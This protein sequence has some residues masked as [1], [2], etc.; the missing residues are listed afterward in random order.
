LK[1][2]WIIASIYLLLPWIFFGLGRNVLNTALA[3][4]DGILFGFP[5]KIFS[6][7]FELWNPMVQGGMYVLTDP[8]YQTL[9][10]PGIVVMKLFSSPFGYNLLLLMHYS[11]AGFFT[12]LFLRLLK[13]NK[14]SSFIGGLIFMFSG[15]LSAHKSHHAMVMAAA[16]LPVTLYFIENYFLKFDLKSLIFAA[17]SLAMSVYAGYPAVTV[18]ICIVTIPYINYKVFYLEGKSKF[19]EITKIILIIYVGGFFLTTAQTLPVYESLNFLTRSEISYSFFTDYSYKFYLL[20]LMLFPNL[21]GNNPN[22]NITEFAGYVGLL[23]LFFLLFSFIF[24][25]KKNSQIYF[26]FFMVI[27]SF[28]LVLGNST[29]FYK[30]MYH[31]P[32]YNLFRVP[33]RN[34]LEVNFA[35]AVLSAMFLH[36][37]VKENSITKEKYLK[38]LLVIIAIFL[39]I[40]SFIIIGNFDSFLIIF[41]D[42]TPDFSLFLIFIIPIIFF[43]CSSTLM[44]SFYGIRINRLFQFIILILIFLDL[45]SFGYFHDAEYLISANSLKDNEIVSF[46]KNKKVST[47]KYRILPLKFENYLENV[48]PGFNML[49]D[50]NVVNG[51]G[52]IWLQ[53]YVDLTDFV[54]TGMTNST[55]ELLANP[56]II[57][58]LSTKY[59]IVSDKNDKE[60]I[61]S[62]SNTNELGKETLVVN[63]GFVTNW[64]MIN[65]LD[66][67]ENLFLLRSPS[68]GQV[69]LIQTPFLIKSE[70][71]YEISFSVQC[72]GN[73]LNFAEPLFVD[74][75][76]L[77]NSQAIY[78][79]EKSITASFIK[80]NQNNNYKILFYAG[81]K[82]VQDVLLRI[83]TFSEQP[84][85][86]KNIRLVEMDYLPNYTCGGNQKDCTSPYSKVYETESG[87]SIYENN[88]FLPRARFV[89]QLLPV[90]SSSTAIQLLKY[91]Y[92]YDL[93]EAAYV[94]GL[95]YKWELSE[96]RIIKSDFSSYSEVYLKV[97][98]DG[99]AFLI[100][101]DTWYPGWKVFINGT[102]GRIYRVNGVSRGVFIS[103]AGEH[104]IEFKFKP[105]SFY[106]GLT[107]S[108]LTFIIMLIILFKQG[109]IQKHQN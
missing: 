89:T 53:D 54:I 73:S 93:R 15:F 88:N 44:F 75:Y 81:E 14:Y 62:I 61:E 78:G 25:R 103:E 67:E 1:K 100:L 24:F 39:L 79:F 87:V 101:S 7:R 20:P 98:T 3:S 32:I 90:D 71:Y 8:Q 49:Y 5:S 40:F 63:G 23:P 72:V 86:I 65:V 46:L 36:Y 16:Y 106:L 108:S 27:F 50:I 48:Y 57:S 91:S 33:A 64:D 51:F 19:L 31:V 55:A 74:F 6:S 38:T 66:K 18:Y 58:V 42:S 28:L 43:I 4:S 9:Y 10:L 84:Y 47:D 34:W 69:S 59:L 80:N 26:W 96:G 21:Y 11:I 22:F 17:M 109:K 102:Q 37:F 52:P 85:V 2:D 60:M 77:N 83:F 70:Q 68:E 95:E 35:I 97:K 41:S 92:D 104:H 82:S 56:Q 107:V 99:P 94:E 45:F 29:P 13:L 76:D 12:Y 30:L 105:V